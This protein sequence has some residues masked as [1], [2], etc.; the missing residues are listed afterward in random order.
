[1]EKNPPKI[2]LP[3]N[4]VIKEI[5]TANTVEDI[6]ILNPIATQ[7]KLSSIT[8]KGPIGINVDEAYT[9]DKRAFDATMIGAMTLFAGKHLIIL[10]NW[11]CCNK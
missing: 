3:K 9:E 11:F 1:M 8:R 6:N 7:Q 2:S 5:L 10:Y 4:A